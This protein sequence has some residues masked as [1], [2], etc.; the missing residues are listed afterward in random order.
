MNQS[1]LL[2]QM[3]KL[4]ITPQLSSSFSVLSRVLYMHPAL[5]PAHHCSSSLQLSGHII[6]SPKTPPSTAVSQTWHFIV[7]INTCHKWPPIPF[8]LRLAPPSLSAFAAPPPHLP[9]I[10]QVGFNSNSRKRMPSTCRLTIKAIWFE[11]V[12]M[13]LPFQPN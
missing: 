9:S 3:Y 7:F 10:F 13:S 2:M 4:S 11:Y 6:I 8:L 12:T 5:V 1:D